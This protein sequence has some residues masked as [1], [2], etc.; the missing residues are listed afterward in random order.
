MASTN[1][2]FAW[3][4]LKYN[5]I[6]FSRILC[7]YNVDSV[8]QLRGEGGRAAL[9]CAPIAIKLCLFV[10]EYRGFVVV[11]VVVVCNDFK[12]IVLSMKLIFL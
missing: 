5:S 8:L 12:S 11:V 2:Y 10:V 9:I 3:D 6:Y 1:A 7:Y 4:Y